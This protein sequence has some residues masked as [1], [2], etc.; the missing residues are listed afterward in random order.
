V[1]LVTPTT[2]T[3]VQDNISLVPLLCSILHQPIWAG[4]R[5]NKFTG[6]LTVLAG[7]KRRQLARQVG[8]NCVLTNTF[9]LSSRWVAFSS[10][11]SPGRCSALGVSSSCL[12]T[13]AM[14]WYSSPRSTTT[15]TIVSSPDGGELDDDFPPWQKRNTRVCPATLLAGGGG[16]GATVAR[17]EAAPRRLS[18]QSESTM[19][20]PLRGTCRVLSFYLRQ[21]RVSLPRNVPTPSG[22]MTPAPSRRTCWALAS[23]LR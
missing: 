14:T 11:F 1:T 23:Y 2:S 6:R 4:A 7:L 3:P 10:L 15:T 13:A 19:P 16:D 21:R 8:G 22:L 17:Q 18:D 9:P 12:A 5:S 20:A